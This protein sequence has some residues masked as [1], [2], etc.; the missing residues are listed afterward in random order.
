[1]ACELYLNKGA[2]N[3]SIKNKMHK[4]QRKINESKAAF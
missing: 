4:Q 3:F 2:I 1:M